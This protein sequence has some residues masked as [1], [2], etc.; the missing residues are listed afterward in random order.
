MNAVV[1]AGKQVAGST[2]MVTDSD[3]NCIVAV[4]TS[5]KYFGNMVMA[6]ATALQ[7]GMQVALSIVGGMDSVVSEFD[8]R[9]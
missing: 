8:S 5:T 6:E 3:S 1:G 7:W 4:V 2:V 9:K